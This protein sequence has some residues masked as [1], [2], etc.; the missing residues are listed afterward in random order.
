[1]ARFEFEGCRYNVTWIDSRFGLHRKG[2]SAFVLALAAEFSYGIAIEEES[3]GVTDNL[4]EALH[5]AC[6]GIEQELV[7]ERYERQATSTLDRFYASL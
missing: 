3:H 5:M 1:M 2:K 4:D 7:N 6:R